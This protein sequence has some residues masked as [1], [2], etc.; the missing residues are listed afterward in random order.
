MAGCF[1]LLPRVKNPLVVRAPQCGCYLVHCI[2]LGLG[3]KAEDAIEAFLGL[4]DAIPKRVRFKAD[5][6]LVVLFL[7]FVVGPFEEV[8]VYR[9]GVADYLLLEVIC[10]LQI[11]KIR[12]DVS[13]DI[14]WLRKGKDIVVLDFDDLF[15]LFLGLWLLLWLVLLLFWLHYD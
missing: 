3:L 2:S 9:V 8:V 6:E 4:L 1:L 14:L 5:F 7:L 11:G 10:A 15:L 13:G 12:L